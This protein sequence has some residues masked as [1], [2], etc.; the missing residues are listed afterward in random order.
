[1]KPKIDI[2]AKIIAKKREEIAA[3]KAEVS[4]AELLRLAD[5][6]PKPESLIRH[7]RESPHLP[8]I[9][10]LKKASPS[11]GIIRDDFDVLAL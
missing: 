5:E 9:A 11:A 8:V 10:E 1:M 7:L 3:R 4:I 2:L 6:A